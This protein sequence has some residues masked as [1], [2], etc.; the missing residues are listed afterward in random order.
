MIS[1]SQAISL[2][3]F[4]SLFPVLRSDCIELG[5]NDISYLVPDLNSKKNICRVGN[6]ARVSKRSQDETLDFKVQEEASKLREIQA[7]ILNLKLQKANP[8]SIAR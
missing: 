5:F 7:T 8:N 3:L 1:V 4:Y 2:S 6:P